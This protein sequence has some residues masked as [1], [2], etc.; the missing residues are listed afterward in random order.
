MANVTAKQQPGA[1]FAPRIHTL[2]KPAG[3]MK[4]L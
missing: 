1:N 3:G 2:Q 4:S